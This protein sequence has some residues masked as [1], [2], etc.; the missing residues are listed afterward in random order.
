MVMASGGGGGGF[1]AASSG[2][3]GPV[4]GFGHLGHSLSFSTS[5]A[6]DDEELEVRTFI[7]SA[8]SEM[9]SIANN[10]YF[11]PM[12]LYFDW[13]GRLKLHDLSMLHTCDSFVLNYASNSKQ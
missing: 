12:W 4:P 10:P 11:L 5:A 2:G 9:S 8:K 13:Q 1:G 3:G 7:K 6:A